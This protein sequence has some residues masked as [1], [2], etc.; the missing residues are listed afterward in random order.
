MAENERGYCVCTVRDGPNALFSP[1]GY[2]TVGKG[3]VVLPCL[4]CPARRRLYVR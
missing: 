3:Q 1:C 2:A 4:V